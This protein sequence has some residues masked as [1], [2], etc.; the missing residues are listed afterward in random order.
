[1][2]DIINQ[3]IHNQLL[4]IYLSMNLFLNSKEL[5][6]YQNNNNKMLLQTSRYTTYTNI[7][8]ISNLPMDDLM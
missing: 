6:F 7:Q 2:F 5:F 1:M 4:F 8:Y 3:I